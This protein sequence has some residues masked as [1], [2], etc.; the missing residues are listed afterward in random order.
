MHC[1]GM[2]AYLYIFVSPRENADRGCAAG[3]GNGEAPKRPRCPGQH[4][5]AAILSAAGPDV[6]ARGQGSL[7]THLA[8]AP[9][10]SR[11][12]FPLRDECRQV[13]LALGRQSPAAAGD[14]QVTGRDVA[15]GSRA[16][17]LVPVQNDVADVLAVV[18]LI[19]R[20]CAV[21][22]PGG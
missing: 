19:L 2:C 9:G 1:F 16:G 10:S 8:V 6:P 12:R 21:G 20:P 17:G 13:A 18:T 15:R 4:P 5:R 3:R 22:E 14:Q 11:S 7:A